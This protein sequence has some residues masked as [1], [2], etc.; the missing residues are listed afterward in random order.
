MTTPP[1]F[2]MYREERGSFAQLPLMARAL[3]G[4]VLKLTDDE[5]RIGLGGKAP[6][7]AVAFALGADRSDRRAL[8]K[9]LPMLLEDGCLVLEDDAL[10]APNWGG[11]Q[12]EEQVAARS[13]KAR[14]RPRTRHE[15]TTNAPR[16]LR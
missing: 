6:E 14:S 1:W 10:L 8:K 2:K 13:R 9:Y 5:G 12:G 7:D 4:E 15:P 16:T 11:F 3:F